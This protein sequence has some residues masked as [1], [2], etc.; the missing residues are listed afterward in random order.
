VI[1]VFGWFGVAML[2]DIYQSSAKVYIDADSVLTPLLRGLTVEG[3]LS[4]ELELLQQM[5]LAR[6]NVERI[7]EKTDLQLDATTPLQTE[8]LVSALSQQIKVVA[9]DR[10]VFTI[11]YRNPNRQLAADVVQAVL[12]SFIENKT[13]DR[14][15]DMARATTFLDSQIA[16]YET[17]LR[18]AEQRRAAFRKKYIDL[19]PG[20]GGGGNRLDQARNQVAALTGQLEDA[21]ARRTL[22]AHEVATTPAMESAEGGGPGGGPGAALRAAEDKLRSLQQVYTDEYPEVVTQKRL[23]A[24]MQSAGT[25]GGGTA[26]AGRSVPNPVYEQLKLRL[27]DTDGQ[28]ESL[29]R[30]VDDARTERDKLEKMAKNVP[31]VEA[32]YSNLNRD[33]D[34]LRT[35]YNELITRRE[36]IRISDAAQKKAS[37]IKMVIIDP[38]TVPRVPVG[39]NRV[40]LAVGVLLAGL[41]GA[42][43]L[44]TGLISF[45]QTFHTLA[46]LKA[47][48]LPVI[49][50]VSL[51]AIPQTPAE[52]TRQIAL[53]SGAFAL[54]AATLLGVLMHFAARS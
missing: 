41:G 36:G 43:G 31:E 18:D 46:D 3:S 12:A 42:G 6:P 49:G 32:Q 33:Y 22:L 2:P 24:S 7:I 50:S 5:L 13:G 26:S 40:L 21:L 11:T 45:D 30:Q 37:N 53:V 8:R 29:T 52:R 35:N 15:E 34:V 48:G 23:V 39:P 16:S 4:D 47:L 44:V 9:Q 14:R 27:V 20:D 19:L 10:S 38:P 1:C 51:A 54:L 28:I 17:Q 25:G